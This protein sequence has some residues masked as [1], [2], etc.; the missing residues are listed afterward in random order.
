MSKPRA[1]R[2]APSA[3]TLRN[4]LKNKVA[5][6]PK[7]PGVYLLKDAKGVV[8]YVGKAKSLRA[9]VRGYFQEHLSDTRRSLPDLMQQVADVEIIEA[10]SEVD[11]LLMEARLIKDIQPYY[12]ARMRDDK[13][14]PYLEI[15]RHHDFPRVQITRRRDNPGS[16]F[17]GPFTDTRGLRRSLQLL[18]PV[19][20]FRTC[21]LEISA[22]D[23][24]RRFRRP[25]LLYYIE[26][27]T[28]PCADL[29]DKK[30][31]R[32]QIALLQR[33][34]AGKRKG[35]LT[36]LA[37]EMKAGSE[38][39]QFEKAARL[40]DQIKA[41]GAL[42]KRGKVD[43]FPEAT[44]SPI[45]DPM[46][47]LKEIRRIFGLR[48]TPRTIDGVDIS[49]LSGAD[50]VG[51][52]AA[53]VDGKPFKA[54]YRRFRIKSVAG[55]DDFAMISEIVTRRFKRLAADKAPFP[56]ILLVDGGK[57]QLGAALAVFGSL[58][59]RPP[60]VI[61]IAKREEILYH[62]APPCEVKLKRNAPALRLLQYVRDEA[63]RFAVHY[64]HILR[65]KRIRAE[66]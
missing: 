25:C 60:K 61:S 15:T 32:K 53:F 65:G 20:R 46:Q 16:K 3:R 21:T 59:I 26:R 64:H 30:D 2:K 35:V 56:D 38:A 9:R 7:C 17:Y 45:V 4:Q 18:Q 10:E 66:I 51:S 47:G 41:L 29:V 19:F 57:G 13:L 48:K 49:H 52:V 40:R 24:K 5:E 63:H 42:G 14:Y 39:L 44:P 34:L 6:F 37:K 50:S 54:G 22:N 31:Y 8:L 1:T 23:A 11:A 12:N 36:S 28:A 55:I 62:G 33:F 27:C 58:N 43:F